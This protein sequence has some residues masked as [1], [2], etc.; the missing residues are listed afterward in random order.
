MWDGESIKI[1]VYR[2]FWWL[3]TAEYS[4]SQTP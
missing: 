1:L 2:D 3:E 4:I